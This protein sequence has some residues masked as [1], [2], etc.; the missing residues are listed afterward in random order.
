MIPF[1]DPI[2]VFEL[3]G[4]SLWDG[5]ALEIGLSKYPAR[6]GQVGRPMPLLNSTDM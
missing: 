4:E 1:D 2:V 3:D 6:G 5:D